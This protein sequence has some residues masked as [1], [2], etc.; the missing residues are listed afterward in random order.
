M[1]PLVVSTE[2]TLAV[3][4]TRPFDSRRAARRNVTPILYAAAPTWAAEPG[5]CESQGT[6]PKAGMYGPPR[7]VLTALTEQGAADL[8]VDAVRVTMRRMAANDELL[9][10]LGMWFA[11][12]PSP[13]F[14]QTTLETGN[15][16][17]APLAP[18]EDTADHPR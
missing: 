3:C 17:A 12:P 6:P 9:E 13:G 14:K 11:F 16:A 7:H 4:T 8:T 18:G 15:P 5:A 10:K 2:P 1:C